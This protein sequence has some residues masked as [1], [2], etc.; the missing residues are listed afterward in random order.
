VQQP[1][2]FLVAILRQLL[3][4]P[5]PAARCA[6]CTQRSPQPATAVAFC[7]V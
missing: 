5:T 1:A 2:L 4:F 6:Q 3:D 7:R